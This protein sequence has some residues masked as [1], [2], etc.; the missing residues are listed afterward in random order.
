MRAATKVGLG[1]NGLAQGLVGLALLGWHD[2]R[3]GG[4][5]LLRD[6]GRLE[7][8]AASQHTCFQGCKDSGLVFTL[9]QPVYATGPHLEL[10]A[11]LSCLLQSDKFAK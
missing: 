9:R 2:L 8:R 3:R 7:S 1:L 11:L 5:N 10:C 4:L 6:K